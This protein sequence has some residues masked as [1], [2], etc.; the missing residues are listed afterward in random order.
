MLAYINPSKYVAEV[1]GVMS[2]RWTTSALG[3][4]LLSG[5]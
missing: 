2:F 1:E 3:N 4:D 5:R